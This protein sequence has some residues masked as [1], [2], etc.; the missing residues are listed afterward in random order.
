MLSRL[1]SDLRRTWPVAAAVVLTGV[2]VFVLIGK[3]AGRNTPELA[4]LAAVQDEARPGTFEVILTRAWGQGRF[5]MLSFDTAQGGHLAL[6]FTIDQG[7]GWRAARL[8]AQR[9]ETSDVKG[10]AG[11]VGSLLVADSVGGK[12]QP[13]WSAVFGRLAD[14]RVTRV[15]VRWRGGEITGADRT[16]GAYLVLRQGRIDP[17]LVRFASADGETIAEV[18]VDPST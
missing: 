6:V 17:E 7:R 9:A 18:D 16:S 15:D 4:A 5:V 14:D 8:S 1:R 3:P 10:H 13:A 11:D 12:G 2:A